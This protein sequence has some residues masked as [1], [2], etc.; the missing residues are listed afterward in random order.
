MQPVPV[1]TD[2][3]KEGEEERGALG[4]R[5]LTEPGLPGLRMD[6]EEGEENASG[7]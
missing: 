4:G 1:G 5:D 7:A 6:E 3:E 2:G